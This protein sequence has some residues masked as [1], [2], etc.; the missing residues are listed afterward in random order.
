[1]RRVGVYEGEW[2]EETEKEGRSYGWREREMLL[3][4]NSSHIEDH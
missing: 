3:P 1:M 4:G 2:G